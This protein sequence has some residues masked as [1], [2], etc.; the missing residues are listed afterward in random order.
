MGWEVPQDA[1]PADPATLRV[2]GEVPATTPGEL[3]KAVRT[4]D[5][6]QHGTWP[7]D[8]KQRQG[9]LWRW[10]DLLEEHRGE[11]VTSLVAES[12]KPVR[13]AGI[14]VTGVVDALRYNAGMARLVH[15]RAGTLPDGSQA[16]LVR[17]PVGVTAFI[18]PWNWPLLLLLRDLAPALAAGVTA[19]V[20][21][22][23]QT[24]LV[25]RR[26]LELARE[27]GIGEDVVRLVVGDGLV[28]ERLVTHPLVRAVAFTGSTAVGAAIRAAA[29]PDM[30]RALLELGGKASMTVFADARVDEAA[31]TAARAA[32]ITAGQM[33]MACTR[34]LVQR[35]VFARVRDTVVDVLRTLRTGDPRDEATDVGPLISG[36]ALDR[37]SEHIALARSSA[38]V[39]TGGERLDRP[40]H[41]V[42]P[43]AVT[44]LR[45]DS[46]LVQHDLFGPLLSIEPFDDEDE[47]VTLANAT[48]YGLAASVWTADLDRAWRASRRIRAGTVWVNGYNRSYAEMPSGGYGSSGLG[49][50]RGVEGIEQ[51]TELKHVHFGGPV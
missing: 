43:A 42:T 3:D 15:G 25:T 45:V 4:A 17:E 22:A 38:R 13:E 1:R 50:T 10:A 19:L 47:A 41:F 18:V 16:H 33:C 7:V 9:L 12:G 48:P 51:F 39:L 21:P 32:V 26:A 29:A 35:P 30:T 14:E 8:A 36:P 20:K 2:L 49:R 24:T 46:P 27:A 34:L 5:E 40:G 37:F 11:L 28:G 23:P 44:G 31:E 6:A